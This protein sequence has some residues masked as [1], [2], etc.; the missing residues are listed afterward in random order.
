MLTFIFFVSPI[1]EINNRMLKKY[2]CFTSI[3][4]KAKKKSSC[5][6]NK[7]LDL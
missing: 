7:M 6:K 2:V 3:C 1:L 4:P 5:K